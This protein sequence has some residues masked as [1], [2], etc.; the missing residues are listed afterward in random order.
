MPKFYYFRSLSVILSIRSRIIKNACTKVKIW[1]YRKR[2]IFLL[3][4]L[5]I[6]EQGD[7]RGNE[8]WEINTSKY[9]IF[10]CLEC[11]LMFLIKIC[12][13]SN[14][15]IPKEK[16]PSQERNRILI[17]FRFGQNRN[18][19]FKYRGQDDIFKS[20]LSIHTQTHTHTHTH[21]YIFT[22]PSARAGYDTRSIF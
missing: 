21:I 6:Y 13:V 10:V 16:I 12:I 3:T 22:N 2:I 14:R 19:P 7:L 15:L 4:R 17:Y 1:M 5:A 8:W 9:A 20:L 11:R 18:Q